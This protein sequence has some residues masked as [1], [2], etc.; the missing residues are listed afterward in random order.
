VLQVFHEFDAEPQLLGK[1]PLRDA[2]TG[3]TY[4][5]VIDEQDLANYR[6]VWREHQE[7]LRRY[8]YQYSIGLTQTRADVPLQ[9]CLERIMMRAA[10]R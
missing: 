9:Q 4:L 10:R 8:C 7:S 5:H 3:Q 2:T 1:F 6:D